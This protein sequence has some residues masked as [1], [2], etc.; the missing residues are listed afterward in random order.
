Q[1]FS[2][3]KGERDV[4][5]HQLLL[6]KNQEGY[7]NLSTLCSLGFIEGMYSGYPRIDKELLVKYHKGLVA[8]SCC[9]G[10]EI[11][12]AILSGDVE[13]AENLVKWWLDLF[14]ED[15]YIEIQRQRGL[16]QID[17]TGMSQEDVN[18]ILLG[19]A[20]KYN[21]KVIATNDAHYVNE[22]DAL[23]HD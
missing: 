1:Q 2:P 23:P 9:T 16:E 3:S 6:A 19:F 20:R 8:T 7:Q 22:Q 4:R 21:I 14:G 13:K 10:A 5:H 17:D 18:N 12:Q 11:P 15:F